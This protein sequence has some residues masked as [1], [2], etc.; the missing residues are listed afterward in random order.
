MN[1]DGSDARTVTDLPDTTELSPAWSPDSSQLIFASQKGSTVTLRRINVDGSGLTQLTSDT[2]ISWFPCWNWATGLVAYSTNHF[3]P[4]ANNF[5]I[6]TMNADGSGQNRLTF[7]N[8]T[9]YFPEWSPDGT[10]LAFVSN[11]D[12]NFEIYITDASGS[13]TRRLTDNSYDDTAPSWQPKP[14]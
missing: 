12:G 9:T 2:A 6:A 10:M 3:G 14:R 1:T 5:D 8:A 7:T 13:N 11:S 4:E